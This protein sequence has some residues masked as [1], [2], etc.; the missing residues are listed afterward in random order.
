M[1]IEQDYKHFLLDVGRQQQLFEQ[2]LAQF[3]ALNQHIAELE[4]K[5]DTCPTSRAKLARLQ[6]FRESD[7]PQLELNLRERM[8]HLE[9]KFT[10]MKSAMTPPLS[11]IQSSKEPNQQSVVGSKKFKRNFL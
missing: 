4:N 11:D 6:A 10:E 2:K 1:D 9:A 8:A 5:A 7:M 3:D